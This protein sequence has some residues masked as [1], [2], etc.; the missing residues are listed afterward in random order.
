MTAG[1]VF[2]SARPVRARV[3]GSQPRRWDPEQRGASFSGLAHPLGSRALSGGPSRASRSAFG[4]T[5]APS[6]GATAISTRRSHP[7]GCGLGALTNLRGCGGEAYLPHPFSPF[8]SHRSPRLY[9][10]LHD[11]SH[12]SYPFNSSLV[13]SPAHLG[14]VIWVRF[15]GVPAIP[16]RAVS[17]SVLS[18]HPS[19]SLLPYSIFLHQHLGALLLLSA[20]SRDGFEGHLSLTLSHLAL[21]VTLA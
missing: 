2:K 20:T 21:R 1:T 13:H 15:I 17:F 3:A 18:R 16:P 11:L 9:S 4:G 14:S 12:G 7:A 8:V 6:S 10:V 19:F 5:P